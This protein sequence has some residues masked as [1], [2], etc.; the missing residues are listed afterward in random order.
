MQIILMG[1]DLI[2]LFSI[3]KFSWSKFFIFEKIFFLSFYNFRQLIDSFYCFIALS[4]NGDKN[5]K[6]T[7]KDLSNFLVGTKFKKY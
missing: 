4:F 5:V 7:L 3:K 1:K 6:F 2:Y